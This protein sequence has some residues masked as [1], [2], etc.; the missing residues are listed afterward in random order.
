MKSIENVLRKA[1]ST[2]QWTTSIWEGKFGEVSV[3]SNEFSYQV[4]NVQPVEEPENRRRQRNGWIKVGKTV[5]SN[6]AEGRPVG[7]IEENGEQVSFHV[8]NFFKYFLKIKKK[9]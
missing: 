3:K 6:V 7:V 8:F 1:L 5:G 2:N 4:S 9:F